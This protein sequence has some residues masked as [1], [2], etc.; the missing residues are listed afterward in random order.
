MR[1]IKIQLEPLMSLRGVDNLIAPFIVFAV[2]LDLT[3]ATSTK[4]KPC[5]GEES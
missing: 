4:S 1:R 3:V 5:L 2:V